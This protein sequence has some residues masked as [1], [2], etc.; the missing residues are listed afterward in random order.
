MKRFR[1]K[2]INAFTSGGSPGNPAACVFL[3]KASDITEEEMQRLARELKGFVSEVVY[4]SPERDE[5][6]LRYYSSECEVDFCGHGTVAAMYDHIASNPDLLKRDE[7]S[8]IVKGEK[9]TVYNRISRENSVYIAAPKADFLSIH[10]DAKEIATALEIE[11]TAI[12]KNRPVGFVRCGLATLIVPMKGLSRCLA[13]YPSQESLRLF[14]LELGIDIILVYSEETSDPRRRYRT[15]VFAPK[16]GYLEDPATGSG[17]S[18]FGHYLLHHSMWDGEALAI[19]QGP[20]RENPNI[21]RIASF[22]SGEKRGVMFGGSAQVKI[23]G[24]Y[25][26]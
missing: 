23:E 19:E 10:P 5:S 3:D 26:L 8:I 24:E 21:V 2:K 12:D 20:D 18:A 14:C 17:N 4:H 6:L 13:L 9:L 15:R 1:F 11:V 22:G 16:Y 7:I 25:I